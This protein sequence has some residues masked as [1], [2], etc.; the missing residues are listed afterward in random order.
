MT[1]K[2]DILVLDFEFTDIDAYRAQPLQVGAVLLDK[3]TLAEKDS[4]QSYIK[5][6][7]RNAN[8]DSMKVNGI[9]AEDL[10]NAPSPA[11]VGQAVFEKF[12]TEVILASFVQMKDRVMFDKIMSEAGIDYNRYDYHFLD[13]WP[14]AYI[15]LR[16]QGQTAYRSEEIFRAF[17]L[18]GR[19]QH[20]ALDDCRKAAD[21]LRRVVTT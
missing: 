4:Y 17:G 15:Y 14:L 10:S 20:Q 13:I 7:I 9:T 1:F 18:A 6:D 2:N 12:G 11:E 21:V 5:S 16:K 19:T 3:D 8:P